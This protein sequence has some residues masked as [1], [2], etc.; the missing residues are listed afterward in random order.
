MADIGA[1]RRIGVYVFDGVQLLDV[2]GPVEVFHAANLFGATY[3]IG[4]YS[5]D[6]ATVL[7][8]AG[9]GLTV[10]GATG[11]APDLDTLIVAGSDQLPTDP[12]VAHR[13]LPSLRPLAERSRRLA[14]VCTGAFLLA[15][16]GYLNGGPAT[17]HWRYADD[18]RRTYGRVDVQANAIFIR[19][20]N[21]FTSAG[22]TAGI[23]LSLALVEDDCGSEVARAV[24]RELVVFMQRPGGQ[25]Q[26]SVPNSIPV[27]D[28]SP[29]RGIVERINSDPTADLS[30]TTLSRHA[31]M[32]TRNFSRRFHAEFSCTPTRYVEQIRLEAAR[33]HLESGVSVT[34]AARR[35]GLGSDETLR[36]L[37][38]K[39]HGISPSAY[40]KRF[41]TT[42]AALASE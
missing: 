14:S 38:A 34:E 11:D 29:M 16:G 35:S 19:S 10:S 31:A 20:G 21:V 28:A 1:T 2:T 6:G 5:P 26:F 25:S 18:L 37:F 36:R 13:L 23:D 39:T 42:R 4:L 40:Q 24:A 17:T 32:S 30:V 3:D 41:S 27:S 12:G 7:S 22:V 15:E 9:V 33:N 8:S